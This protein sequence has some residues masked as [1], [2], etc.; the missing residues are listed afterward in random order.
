MTTQHTRRTDAAA[1]GAELKQLRAAGL[2]GR[3]GLAGADGGDVHMSWW[4]QPH[5][6]AGGRSWGPG[7]IQRA[8]SGTVVAARCHQSSNAAAQPRRFPRRLAGRE[9]VD[10]LR[11]EQ[12]AAAPR[13]QTELAGPRHA[14]TRTV[15]RAPA[16]SRGPSPSRSVPSSSQRRCTPSSSSGSSSIGPRQ[17]RRALAA[18]NIGRHAGQIACRHASRKTTPLGAVGGP[19]FGFWAWLRGSGCPDASRRA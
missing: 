9:H 11:R 6:R 13:A 8:Q 16:G 3:D 18:K 1:W 5:A 10:E 4:A 7:G 19:E 15:L 12:A 14:A 2:S 17:R